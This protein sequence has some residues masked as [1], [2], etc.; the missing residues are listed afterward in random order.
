[1]SKNKKNT[2]KTETPAAPAAKVYDFCS[3]KKMILIIAVCVL[4]AFIA[5]AIVRGINL[6]I[7]FEGGTLLTYSYDGD[8]NTNDVQSEVSKQ[9]S[10]PVTVRRGESLDNSG[11]QVTIAFTSEDGFNADAQHEHQHQHQPTH[12]SS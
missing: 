5:G 3:K 9:I 7:E 11:Y 8:L 2:A 6:A 12:D 10:S 1:M 4:V